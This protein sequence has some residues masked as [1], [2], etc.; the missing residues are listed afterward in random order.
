MCAC[1]YLEGVP[2]AVQ[3]PEQHP[4][5]VHIT[6]TGQLAPKHHLWSHVG[7]RALHTSS[8]G[9][10]SKHGDW[11]SHLYGTLCMLVWVCAH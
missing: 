10:S 3:L 6:L 5:G 2:A 9:S 1:A 4:K 11:L 8:S 7:H